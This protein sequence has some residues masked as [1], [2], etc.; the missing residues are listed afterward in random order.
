[1]TLPTQYSTPRV[2]LINCRLIIVEAETGEWEHSKSN[3][4]KVKQKQY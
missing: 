1:M 2:S 4:D 3:T